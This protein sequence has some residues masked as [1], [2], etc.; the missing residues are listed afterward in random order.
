MRRRPEDWKELEELC[1]TGR[2]KPFI[3]NIFP[4]AKAADAF[5]LAVNGK[6]RGKIIV[7][8]P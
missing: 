3:E 1:A 8:V 7:T 4:L 2:L 6:P 5:D